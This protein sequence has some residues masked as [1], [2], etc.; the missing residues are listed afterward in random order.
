M[1]TLNHI[2][3]IMDGNGRWAT[4]KGKSRSRGHIAGVHSLKKI[5]NHC[6]DYRIPNISIYAFSTENWKRPKEEVSFLFKLLIEFLHKYL[7]ILNRKGVRILHS[8]DNTLLEKELIKEIDFAINKTS[9][10]KNL[11]LNICL[12]YGSKKELVTAFKN[13]YLMNQT[14]PGEDDI[15]KYLYNPTLPPLDL[16][17]RTG[18]E[19]RLSNF[20]LW[21]SSYA[22]IY[23]EDKLWPDYS[24]DDLQKAIYWFG[25]RER[26][27]GGL[28]T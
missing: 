6:V 20:M 12:N 1:K 7:E 22:E 21:Q 16:I 3:F 13:F 24:K 27:F 15:D 25:N 2:G 8:G 14:F 17:I 11:N 28:N 9:K 23:F 18:G 19:R 26:R 4:K 10:N 5:I